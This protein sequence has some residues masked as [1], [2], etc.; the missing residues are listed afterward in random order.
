MGSLKIKQKKFEFFVF[1]LY[2]IYLSDINL[3]DLSL[4][5]RKMLKDL[6]PT[7]FRNQVFPFS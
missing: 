7:A 3:K 4:M 5:L 2:L 1:Q 6:I